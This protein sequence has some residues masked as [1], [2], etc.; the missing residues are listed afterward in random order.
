MAKVAPYYTNSP[1]YPPQHRQVHHDHD[2]CPDGRKIQPKHRRAG[3]G[4]KPPCK[5]CQKLDQSN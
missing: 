2:N 5:E 3:M 4:G 1:E